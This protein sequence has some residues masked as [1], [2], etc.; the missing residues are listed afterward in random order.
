MPESIEASSLRELRQSLQDLANEYRPAP[1]APSL[2]ELEYRYELDDNEEVIV[3]H[4][5]YRDKYTT[6]QRFARVV[7]E[8]A[9]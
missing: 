4:S 7:H 5:Y 1:H 2:G 3:V 9:M 6:L 8:D